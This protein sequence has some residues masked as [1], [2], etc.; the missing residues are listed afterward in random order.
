[1][2]GEFFLSGVSFSGANKF[3]RDFEFPSDGKRFLNLNNYTGNLDSELTKKISEDTK[4]LSWSMI[5]KGIRTLVDSFHPPIHKFT[6]NL[7]EEKVKEDFYLFVPERDVIG[8]EVVMISATW[9]LWRTKLP[10]GIIYK[11][12]KIEQEEI[13]IVMLDD[14]AITGQSKLGSLDTLTYNNPNVKFN[15]YLLVPF[16]SFASVVTLRDNF[17]N[18]KIFTLNSDF[19]INNVDF[20]VEYPMSDGKSEVI[21]ERMFFVYSDMKIADRFCCPQNF[22]EQTVTPPPY[23]IKETLQKFFP[24]SRISS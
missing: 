24:N 14:W 19:D 2:K 4:Y 16:L 17:P 9:D 7:Q 15:F 21:S 13:N 1:M 3:L 20:S 18:V 10:K 8:S 23:N 12:D 11:N 6:T 5:L 22:Y